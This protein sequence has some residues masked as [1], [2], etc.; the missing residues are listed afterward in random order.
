MAERLSTGLANYINQTGSLKGALAN[1]IISVYSG[2]QPTTADSAETGTLL[3]EFTVD[4]GAF[5]PG[6]ATNGLNMG[7]SSEG[8]LAKSAEVWKGV[9]LAAAGSSG[10]TAGYYRFYAN[11]KVT[12]ASTTAVRMDGS[13][14]TTTISELQMVN[15]LIVTGATSTIETYNITSPKQ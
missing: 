3:L 15:P 7:A 6:V 12:G 10:T 2:T 13:I 8:V 9:G 11:A 4:A 14:G 5:T 1:G